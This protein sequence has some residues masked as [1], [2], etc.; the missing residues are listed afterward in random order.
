MEDRVRADE[1]IGL[2][3]RLPD[4]EKHIYEQDGKQHIT[5]EWLCGAFAGRGFEGDTLEEA[6]GQLIDY[7]YLHIG[8]ISMVGMDVARSGF[9]DLKAVEA[10]CRGF[11]ETES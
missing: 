9:P 1:I 5:N 7:L 10:Y 11:I 3:R 6:A 8:H 4:V 2:V